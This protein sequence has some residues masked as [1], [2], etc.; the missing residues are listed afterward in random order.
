MFGL[1]SKLLHSPSGRVA[2]YRAERENRGFV[3]DE[4]QEFVQASPSPRRSGFTLLETI[5][6]VSLSALLIALIAAGMR[7]YT[8]TVQD[9]RADV[10]NARVARTILQRIASDLRSAYTITEEEDS[11]LDLDSLDAAGGTTAGGGGIAAGGPTDQ[12]QISDQPSN[13]DVSASISGTSG[14]SGGAAGT[15][16]IAGTG[17]SG[18]STFDLT[19]STVQATPGIS[20]NQFELQIDVLGRF[21]EP[22]RYDMV[23]SIGGDPLT[24]NLLSE[25]KV[26]TY[27]VRA[28]SSAEL[29]GT[30]LESSES[31]SR[32]SMSILARRVQTRA[33]AS[34]SASSGIS[35]TQSGEQLLSDQVVAIQFQY[36]DGYDW[37]DTWDSATSGLPIA[38]K[39]TLTIADATDESFDAIELNSDN[40]FEMTVRIPTAEAVSA[41]D[42]T[43]L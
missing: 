39:I 10:V 6:A 43:G 41:E 30:P 18:D 29:S 25:P 28:A 15:S 11:S 38:V 23:T 12:T 34:T 21:A 31:N 4:S 5:L 37:T 40:T 2:S 27:Y 33:V 32:E 20:G 8:T 24:S 1:P 35:D 36:H 19:S 9:R 22:V 42:T 26:V 14:T 17:E 3:L 16:G 7:I 13:A